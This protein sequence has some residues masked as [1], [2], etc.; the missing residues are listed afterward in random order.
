MLHREGL[1]HVTPEQVC[2][3][4]ALQVFH[5]TPVIESRP[6]AFRLA[7]SGGSREYWGALV[8]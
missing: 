8:L 7:G 6:I 4:L 1:T 3:A 5:V 2:S